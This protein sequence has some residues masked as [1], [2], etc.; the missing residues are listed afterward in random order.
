[1]AEFDRNPKG[2]TRS[3]RLSAF[4][5]RVS[6]SPARVQIGWAR[7]GIAWLL[8][9]CGRL[10]GDM[11]IDSACAGSLCSRTIVS[12]CGRNT[13]TYSLQNNKFR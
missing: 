1:M 9:R 7:V 5:V 8:R 4:Y 10:V 13:V 3:L 6:D 2:S 11:V 12:L